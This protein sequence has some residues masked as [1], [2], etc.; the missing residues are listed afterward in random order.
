M[1]SKAKSLAYHLSTLPDPRKVRGG[2]WHKE[3]EHEAFRD[4]I[5][6]LKDQL[7]ELGGSLQP[8]GSEASPR[9]FS[10]YSSRVDCKLDRPGQS[11][12]PGRFK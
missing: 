11:H 8:N 10:A 12:R 6:Q 9:Q 4:L 3:I 5:R 2:F 7:Q 1:E